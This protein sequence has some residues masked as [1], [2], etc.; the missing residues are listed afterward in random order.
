[1]RS[2]WRGRVLLDWGPIP[3]SYGWLFPKADTL[4]VGVIA[5]RGAGDQTSRPS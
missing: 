4:T 2:E 5:A 1:M 3:G